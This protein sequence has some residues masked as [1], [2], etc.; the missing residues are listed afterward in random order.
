MYFMLSLS[1]VLT[2]PPDP[3][4]LPVVAGGPLPLPDEEHPVAPHLGVAHL[5]QQLVGRA[6]LRAVREERGQRSLTRRTHAHAATAN[7]NHHLLTIVPLLVSN[8]LMWKL[9]KRQT[10]CTSIVVRSK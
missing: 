3:V 4:V 5:A 2:H 9:N 8:K 6:H 7:L 10:L 1:C